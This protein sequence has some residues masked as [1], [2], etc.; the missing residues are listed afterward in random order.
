MLSTG[1][2]ERIADIIRRRV[3]V[4]PVFGLQ[5]VNEAAVEIALLVVDN[6]IDRND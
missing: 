4:D 3:K 2:I 6:G 1:D 5:G